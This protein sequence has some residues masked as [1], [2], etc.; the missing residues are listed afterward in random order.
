MAITFTGVG[1]GLDAN[2]IIDQLTNLERAPITAFNAKKTS[3]NK[4]LSLL[5]DLAGKLAAVTTAVNKADTQS[6]LAAFK[7]ASNNTAV[8]TA[9]AGSGA[10]LGAHD[11]TVTSLARAETT[12]SVVFASDDPGVAG[13]G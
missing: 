2:S 3:A 4:Q 11:L 1:S 6:E 9:T 5:G 12:Q 8:V 7:V 10:A 13:A